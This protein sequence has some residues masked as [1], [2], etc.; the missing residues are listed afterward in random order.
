[1]KEAFALAVGQVSAE[2]IVEGQRYHV[3]KLLDV[4]PPKVVRYDDVKADVRRQVEDQLEE[5]FITALREQIK[6]AT[7]ADLQL[8]DPVLRQSW[9]AMIAAQ[10]PKGQTLSP[11]DA[12]AKIHRADRPP[13]AT[14]PTRRGE[15]RRHGG[16]R[17]QERKADDGRSICVLI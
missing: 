7:V 12:D 17:P 15:P 6:R 11:G 16:T 1:M 8:D 9:D 4:I 5:Q 3:I 13:A 2:P 14:R 10:Q